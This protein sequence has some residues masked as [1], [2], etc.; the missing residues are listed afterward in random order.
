MVNVAANY[1]SAP[2]IQNWADPW[3]HGWIFHVLHCHMDCMA[4]WSIVLYQT[5]HSGVSL[6]HYQNTGLGHYEFVW[7]Y[8]TCKTNCPLIFCYD[9]C[10]LVWC[11][12]YL[13]KFDKGICQNYNVF[14]TI[15]WRL[16][17]LTLY[18]TDALGHALLLYLVLFLHLH[19]HHSWFGNVD[20]F[21]HNVWHLGTWFSNKISPSIGQEFILPS[22]DLGH[23][24]TDK[25]P[26]SGTLGEDQLVILYIII[27]VEAM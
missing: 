9:K 24:V 18:I 16:Y 7:E 25:E 21:S 26:V 12:K 14:L 27:N 19:N 15:F 11:L 8:H 20:S 3:V 2:L 22:D 4:W 1:L 23:H 5:W 6:F 13:A 17:L 10:L